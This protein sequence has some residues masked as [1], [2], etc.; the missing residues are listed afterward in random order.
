[1]DWNIGLLQESNE[2]DNTE[3]NYNNYY[4]GTNNNRL[5]GVESR[6]RRMIFTPFAIGDHN[7]ISII[8]TCAYI[9]LLKLLQGPTDYYNDIEI[10][11]DTIITRQ[12]M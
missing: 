3:V 6:V 10:L 8:S 7:A 5:E 9:D 1:M 11:M 2:E 4:Q 12:I